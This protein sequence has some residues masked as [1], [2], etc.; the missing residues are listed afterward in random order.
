MYASFVALAVG[1]GIVVAA[2]LLRHR[3]VDYQAIAAV[4]LI[5]C[6]A[7]LGGAKLFS[8]VERGGFVW[9][10]PAWEM[11]HGFRYPGGLLGLLVAAP[12]IRRILPR[13]LGMMSVADGLAPTV[14]VSMAVVRIGCFLGGCCHGVPTSVPWSVRFPPTSPAWE[15]HIARGWIDESAAATVAVHPLQL[16]F[17]L[18]SALL[19]G[20]LATVWRR[21]RRDGDTF[22]VFLLADGLLKLG[23]E[24]LRLEYR[25]TLAGAGAVAAAVG[26]MGLVANSERCRRKGNK[27]H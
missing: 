3:G 24:Q 7:S 2:A 9:W 14:A 6:V 10:E 23:L 27:V 5:G 17:V 21:S 4:L 26:A 22:F 18:S 16:Y 15:A 12:C 20:L 11:T 13:D 19:A 8:V 1:V 25:V